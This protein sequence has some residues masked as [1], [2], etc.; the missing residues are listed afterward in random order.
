[1]TRPGP[2]IGARVRFTTHGTYG[3]RT[4]EAEVTGYRKYGRSG[5]AGWIET[6]DANGYARSVQPARCEI[7]A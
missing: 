7:V 4:Y 5:L 1:M 3:S 2:W 6:I